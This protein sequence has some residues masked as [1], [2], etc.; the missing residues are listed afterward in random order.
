MIDMNIEVGKRYRNAH[1][2][3]ECEVI[4]TSAHCIHYVNERDI[5]PRQ[6]HPDTFKKDWKAIL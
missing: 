5:V 2:G 3:I 6:C 1:A 4:E